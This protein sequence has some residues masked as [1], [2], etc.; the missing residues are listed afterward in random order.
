[1]LNAAAIEDIQTASGG[2]FSIGGA[3]QSIVAGGSNEGLFS[4]SSSSGEPRI[5]RLI[6]NT[7]PSTVTLAGEIDE[8]ILDGDL[9]ESTARPLV[10][11]LDQTQDSLDRDNG[12]AAQRQIESFV[13]RVEALMRSGRL[14]PVD[15]QRLIDLAEELA[16][17]L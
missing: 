6:L 4:S 14:S 2:F 1:M 3:L 5:H 7:A 17:Q 9:T 16:S 15:G 8:L 11:L 12:A 10:V 13:R